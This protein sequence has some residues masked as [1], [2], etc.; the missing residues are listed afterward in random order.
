MTSTVTPVGIN[1]KTDS[2]TS[3]TKDSTAAVTKVSVT[4]PSP[5][6]KTDDFSSLVAF[7][8]PSTAEG[9]LALAKMAEVCER[10]DEMLVCMKRLAKLSALEEEFGSEERHLL[11]VAYKNCVLTRRANWRVVK[12]I[13]QS[14]ELDLQMFQSVQATAS[15]KDQA[16]ASMILAQKQSNLRIAQEF[17]VQLENEIVDVCTDLI[18]LVENVIFPDTIGDDAKM[19]LYKIAGDFYR[20][21]AEINPSGTFAASN[22]L[23]KNKNASNSPSTGYASATTSNLVTPQQNYLANKNKT[24]SASS[25]P[26]LQQQDEYW[27]LAQEAYAKAEELASSLR[28]SHPMRLSISLN[29]A[30]FYYETMRS[31]EK[32]LHLA[33]Q[34]F[35]AAISD[36][37]PPETILESE[38]NEA[39]AILQLLQENLYFW[40]NPQSAKDD[41]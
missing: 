9:L 37:T 18:V 21:L 26:S 13:E 11:H 14:A 12:S 24:A 4:A 32:A 27:V 16:N 22:S 6:S 23:Y 8:I 15:E 30:I 31:H 7:A 36:E 1:E 3:K 25:S 29:L 28:P 34:T 2:S 39:G 35:S 40:T 19:F 38:A 5:S 33:R 17:R 20:Y 41:M 10:W